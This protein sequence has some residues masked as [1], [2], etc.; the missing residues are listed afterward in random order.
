MVRTQQ[1]AVDCYYI[2]IFCSTHTQ[3][4]HLFANVV[5][6]VFLFVNVMTVNLFEFINILMLENEI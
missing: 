2:K 5:T 1:H 3:Q 6:Y 4:Y